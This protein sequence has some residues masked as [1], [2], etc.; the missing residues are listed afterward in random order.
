[1]IRLNFVCLGNICRSPTAEGIMEHLVSGADLQSQIEV[2]SSGT[3][4]FHAG[5]AADRR[6]A[7]TARRRGVNLVGHSRQFIA[8]DVQDFDYNL[9]VDA[10]TYRKLLSMAPSSED[11]GRVFLLRDFDGNSPVDSDVPDPY[12]GGPNGFETVFDICEA[13]CRGLLTYI[14]REHGI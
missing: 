1:M 11:K 13:A 8:S 4:A 6:S 5:E 2:D 10:S 7:A 12:Y 9:A 14:R 3:S